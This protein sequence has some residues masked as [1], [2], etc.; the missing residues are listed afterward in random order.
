MITITKSHENDIGETKN[1][2]DVNRN[3]MKKLKLISFFSK[4]KIS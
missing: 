4:R 3:E 2:T 1:M